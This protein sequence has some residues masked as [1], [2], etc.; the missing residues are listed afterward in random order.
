VA[1][2][3]PPCPL[4]DAGAQTGGAKPCA[5]AATPAFLPALIALASLAHPAEGRWSGIR[6]HT[7][8]AGFSAASGP[9]AGPPAAALFPTTDTLPWTG[10]IDIPHGLPG[11][12]GGAATRLATALPALHPASRLT[13]ASA[14]LLRLAAQLA[15]FRLHALVGHAVLGAD[16]HWRSPAPT[17]RPPA[18]AG[19]LAANP[20]A[21]P[22]CRHSA[23]GPQAAAQ[24]LKLEAAHA[25]ALDGEDTAVLDIRIQAGGEGAQWWI[26]DDIL[27]LAARRPQP[28]QSIDRLRRAV[29]RVFGPP[30]AVVLARQGLVSLRL[31]LDIFP[32]SAHERLDAATGASDAPVAEF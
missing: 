11:H 20:T 5:L 10:W 19:C 15:P 4:L 2:P 24:T 25:L 12:D 9:C 31:L 6:P 22:G 28:S 18:C 30:D 3:T 16:G 7:L 26:G 21:P 1:A 17:I 23:D 14:W 27:S 8:H 13:P 29:R 32:L